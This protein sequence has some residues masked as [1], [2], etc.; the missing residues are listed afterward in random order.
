MPLIILLLLDRDQRDRQGS[1][2]LK[3]LLLWLLTNTTEWGNVPLQLRL[4]SSVLFDSQFHHGSNEKHSL[5]L[6]STLTQVSTWLNQ[7]QPWLGLGHHPLQS[8]KKP[9]GPLHTGCIF[10]WT[11]ILHLSSGQIRSSHLKIFNWVV[12]QIT[13]ELLSVG[14]DHASKIC[15]SVSLLILQR[16]NMRGQGTV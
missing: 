6:K 7:S 9:E 15:Y 13:V 14:V 16:R 8:Y 5:C 10:H 2:R 12:L 3:Q 1:L 4:P 11:V